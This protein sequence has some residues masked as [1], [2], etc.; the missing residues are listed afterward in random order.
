MAVVVNYCAAMLA[1]EAV[2]SIIESESL[3]P[4]QIAVVDN[5]QDIHEAA[6][7]QNELPES[8]HLI[9]NERNEGFALAC[10]R[11]FDQH[12]A[13][14][15]LLLNPDA[16]LLPKAL[17]RLQ[18]SL[19]RL[20]RTGAVGPQIYWDDKKHFFLPPSA[21]PELLWFHPLISA[22]P[23]L[24]KVISRMW[25]RFAIRVW[26]S[27][28]NVRVWNLS[29]GHVL[30]NRKAV[31]AAGGLFDS[32]FFLYYEDTDLFIR[33]RQ[34]GYHLYIDPSA[35][36]VHFYDQCGNFG[37]NAKRSWMAQSHQSFMEKHTRGWKQ[38]VMKIL[39]KLKAGTAN[40]ASLPKN[41]SHPFEIQIPVSIQKQWL[42]EWSPNPNFIPAAGH[43]GIGDTM[44]FP[45][46]CWQLLAPKQYYGRLGSASKMMGR[47]ETISWM[48]ESDDV[49]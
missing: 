34:A 49:I 39:E 13:D 45:M 19:L 33:L 1:V 20:N 30:L 38:G 44:R 23:L 11:A 5:S 35:E 12:D 16:R 10:N 8:V 6:I 15:I 4:V 21:V 46:E 17:I 48:K 14:M 3:G 2:R 31:M 18:Q 32:R 42:F 7:L 37:Q 27:K 24:E 29:G 28:K 9:I 22:H 40:P 47:F 43:F 26:Q 36:V 25:R 41:Y